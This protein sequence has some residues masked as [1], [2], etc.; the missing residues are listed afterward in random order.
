[1][2][3]RERE[4][5]ILK[6]VKKEGY[7]TVKYLVERLHYSNASINR[8]LNSMESQKL[9]R[10]T[11]GGVELIKTHG[12]GALPFR[13]HKEHVAKRKMAHA[14]AEL[15]NDGDFIFIDNTT[16]TQFIVEFLA[17]KKDVTVISNNMAV[18]TQASELG[19]RAICL[20]GAI[21]E[22][23]CMLLSAETVEN[24]MLYKANKAFFSSGFVSEDGD[25]G[26]GGLYT[27]LHRTMVKNSDESYF[28]ADAKKF[29]KE[30]ETKT[31]SM[32]VASVTG[33]ITNRVLG[34]DW[35]EKFPGVRFIEV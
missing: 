1:M 16:T 29:E 3:Q 17:E 26:G 5:E 33:M 6:I 7:V 13:Y 10:R 27:L 23:P 20:G 35:K 2:Y 24:A 18:V 21:M 19:L 11:Y 28:L 14:A 8:D 15:V 12:H 30:Y 9:I 25:I 4:N 22:A 34:K 31:F 32:S